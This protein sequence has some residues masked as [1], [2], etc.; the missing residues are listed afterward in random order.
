ML[1]AAHRRAPGAIL[2]VDENV[3]WVEENAD[4]CGPFSAIVETSTEGG[5]VTILQETPLDAVPRTLDI[6]HSPAGTILFWTTADPASR[7]QSSAQVNSILLPQPL[8]TAVGMATRVAIAGPDGGGAGAIE[9][10]TTGHIFYSGP[11]GIVGQAIGPD[12]RRTGAPSIVPTGGFVDTIEEF[13]TKIY[14]ID[15]STNDLMVAETATAQAPKIVAS[16]LDPASA[17]QVDVACVYWA[18]AASESLTMVDQ[19]SR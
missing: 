17:F 6:L 15:P 11:S 5:P 18:D 16:H 13:G 19:S 1:I 10:S 2:V 14:F 4:E 8:P 7:N 3:V 12:G 9:T